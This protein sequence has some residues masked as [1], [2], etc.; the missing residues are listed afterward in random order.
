MPAADELTAAEQQLVA[1]ATCGQA[2][3]LQGS[4]ALDNP[5]RGTSWGPERMI[6][7]E[8]VTQL[9]TD[10]DAR[11]PLGLLGARIT[12]PLDLEGATLGRWLLLPDCWMDDPV[13]LAHATAPLIRMTGCHLPGLDA[14]DLQVDS[15]LTLDQGFT[16]SGQVKVARARIGGVLSL[17]GATLDNPGATA[18]D[19][20]RL[21]AGH[22]MRLGNGFTA[23]GEVR[24][25]G[26]QIGGD[27]V[28]IGA[29]VSNPGGT[30]LTTDQAQIAQSVLAEGLVADGCI[31][32]SGTRIGGSL[33]L[34]GAGLTH[35]G[36]WA[37]TASGLQV[38]QEVHL[39]GGFTA[40]GG[41]HLQ[42]AHLGALVPDGAE[43]DNPNGFA[44][45]GGWLSVDRQVSC[46]QG[47]VARGEFS[48]YGAHVGARVDLREATLSHPE[49]L[50]VDLE[51]LKASALYLLPHRAPDGLVDLTHAGIGTLH[52]DPATWPTH[53]DLRGLTYQTLTNDHVPVRARPGWLQRQQQGYALQPYDQLAAAHRQAGQEDAARLVAIHKQRRRRH[54]LN[55]A[56]RLLDWLLYLTVGYGYRT[57][58][59]ALWLLALLALGTAVFTHAYPAHITATSTPTPA[60]HPIAYTLDVLVPIIDLGQQ[61]A[62]LPTGSA[63]YCWWLLSGAGWVLTTAVAAGLGGVLKR[64]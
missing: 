12:G 43:L 53:L 40:H 10:S 35:T 8:L 59:A 51:R 6:R 42:A 56:G 5:G 7:A 27:L 39:S 37:L 3:D 50:A 41:I 18:L 9:L 14:E 4:D 2:A 24:L 20:A 58:L 15:D 29:R 63:L 46:R 36:D 25:P 61:K 33:I 54:T 32:V 22:H 30:A 21:T 1:A 34:A 38:A 45:E 11:T 44:L 52:D 60:F 62:W 47:F 26:A 49:G 28:L 55:P 48:L 31:Q 64:N 23:R 16:V 57:W 17:D 13:T 19:A